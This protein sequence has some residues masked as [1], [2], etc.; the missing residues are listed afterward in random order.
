M[1]LTGFLFAAAAVA[2]PVALTPLARRA[3]APVQRIEPPLEWHQKVPAGPAP[4]HA[5][6]PH[7]AVMRFCSWM[8]EWGFEG[9]HPSEDVIGF[10]QWFSA[11]AG[12]EEIDHGLLLERVATAPWITRERKR[13]NG[14][15]FARIKRRL[16]GAERAVLYRVASAEEMAE[17]AKAGRCKAKQTSS[18]GQGR[19][20]PGKASPRTAA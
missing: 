5:I 2:F 6:N 11:D 9:W 3:A 16:G 1:T 8:R 18:K 19:A 15:Q 7:E 17:A 14:Q 10:Y 4:R 12:L 13:L 20:R